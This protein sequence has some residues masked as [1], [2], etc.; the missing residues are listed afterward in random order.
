MKT[1]TKLLDHIFRDRFNH[2]AFHGILEPKYIGRYGKFTINKS[3]NLIKYGQSIKV[4]RGVLI[5]FP[6]L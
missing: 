5:E 2:F 1:S 3:R 6:K 4:D